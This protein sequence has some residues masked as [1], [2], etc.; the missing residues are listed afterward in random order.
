MKYEAHW[1]HWSKLFEQPN[2]GPIT[3]YVKKNIYINLSF[4]GLLLENDI[5]WNWKRKNI[6]K[7]NSEFSLDFFFRW[8]FILA[9]S[10]T[11][12]FLVIKYFNKN[13]AKYFNW[14]YSENCFSIRFRTLR[15][16]WDKKKNNMINC[17]EMGRRGNL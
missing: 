12:F 4:F 2:V 15:I 3:K 13:G 14:F 11:V 9:S 1:R 7:K 10:E 8:F 16:F 17:D 5:R 6:Q